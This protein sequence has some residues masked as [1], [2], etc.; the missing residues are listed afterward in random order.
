MIIPMAKAQ[1]TTI[2]Y[3]LIAGMLVTQVAFL[4]ATSRASQITKKNSKRLRTHKDMAVVLLCISK[5][6][7]T[8]IAYALI[9]GMPLAQQAFL[10]SMHMQYAID[11]LCAF[12]EPLAVTSEAFLLNGDA[13]I[14]ITLVAS[15]VR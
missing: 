12:V 9:A 2:A 7:K 1:K 3:V 13:S 8:S 5:A 11:V 15:L 14:E 4:R 10:R 6:Q